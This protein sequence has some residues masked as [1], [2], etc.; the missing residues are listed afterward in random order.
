MTK[1]ECSYIL[2]YMNNLCAIVLAAGKGTRMK[3]SIPKVLHPVAGH[4]MLRYP[5]DVLRELKAK[6]IMLVVGF[7]ADEVRKA[8]SPLSPLS[9]DK[10][11]F[12]EQGEQLGTGHAV[13]CALGGLKGFKGD[14]LILSGDVP[15]ITSDTVRGLLKAHRSARKNRPAI[16]LITA[17][18]EEPKGYGRIVRDDNGSIVRIVED[19]DCSPQQKEIKEINTGLYLID[20][21]F[22]SRNI[23]KLG[24]ENAQ[25]EY[26]LPDL[27]G[28][29]V[30]EGR[31][32]ASLTHMD[33]NEVMGV[34]NRI[35]LA[36]ANGIM[37]WRIARALMLSG[38]TIVDPINTYIDY[39][40]RV[41][42]DTTIFPGAHLIGNTSIGRNCVIEDGARIENSE[43]GDGSTIKSYSVVEDTKAGKEVSIGPFA[44]LR[45]GSVLHDRVRVGNFVEVKKSV[46]GKNSKANHLTY[47]GDSII[48]EGVN[49]GAGTITCNY[50]GVNKHTTVIED[51]AFIG[52]DSQLV[53]PVK[54]GK[55]AYVGSG[56]TVTRDVP[57][58]SLVITRAAEKVVE[59][60]AEKRGLLKK[61]GH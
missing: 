41:G 33:A 11:S 50:D 36:R 56:T 60:W 6:K 20:S 16:S 8:F 51:G 43:V 48:G 25:G 5:V 39:G 10:V 9:L 46:V 61:K 32:V 4:P 15:L 17:L 29:A 30:K 2:N 35:E 26:Y 31:K 40:V 3:S 23:K 44:R 24:K 59:G 34:N 7:G 19:K 53:A 38:V 22:L 57:A 13:M 18:L 27:I 37:K 14:V 28:L 55:G 1:V 52:S 54:V 49:I 21:G 12:V 45:P 42:M 58:G 47:L